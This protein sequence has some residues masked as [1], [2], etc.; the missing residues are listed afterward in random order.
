MRAQGSHRPPLTDITH[1]LV[2]TISA[3]LPTYKDP[4]V[5]PTSIYLTKSLVFEDS[6]DVE[7]MGAQSK[8]SAT[9]LYIEN[10]EDTS[11]G[12]ADD[13]DP[14]TS[15]SGKANSGKSSITADVI[16]SRFP[17]RDS[18]A[19]HLHSS[20]SGLLTIPLLF[21]IPTS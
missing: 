2:S 8:D 17:S 19:N 13:L 4:R 14:N 5:P 1:D 18:R 7:S 11:T 3:V 20:V 6:C 15:N 9:A 12:G 10:P 21:Q 16:Q